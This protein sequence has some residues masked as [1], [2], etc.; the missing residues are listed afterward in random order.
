[1]EFLKTHTII[2]YLLLKMALREKL[3]EITAT[4]SIVSEDCTFC[5]NINTKGSLKIEGIVEGNI[6]QAKDVFIGKAARVNGDITCERC[7][8]YGQVNGNITACGLI[9]VMSVGSVKGDIIAS[10]IMIEEGGFVCGKVE[11]KR[12]NN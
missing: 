8:V 5:G 1:M 12:T 3:S 11:V 4:E 7:T 2:W 10:K 6:V 9:E